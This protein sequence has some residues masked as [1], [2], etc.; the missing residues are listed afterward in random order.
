MK[1]FKQELEAL[2]LKYQVDIGYAP[3]LV[4]MQEGLFGIVVA[5]DVIDLKY[6]TPSPFKVHKR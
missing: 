1:G 2:R 5:S 3:E 6:R 4:P